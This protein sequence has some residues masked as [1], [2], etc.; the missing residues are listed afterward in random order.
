VLYHRVMCYSV[1]SV[2]ECVYLLLYQSVEYA[3][4]RCIG[5]CVRV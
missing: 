5:A 2:Y 4:I 3:P 1:V